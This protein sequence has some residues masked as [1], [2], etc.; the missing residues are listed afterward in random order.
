MEYLIEPTRLT[1]GAVSWS[2]LAFLALAGPLVAWRAHRSMRE[3]GRPPSSP[4]ARTKVYVGAL[5]WLW[6][7]VLLA[8]SAAR[9]SG[10]V[11]FPAWRPGPRDLAIGALS[12]ALGML[13]LLP[14]VPLVSDEG[15]ARVRAVAP[16]TGRERGLF[17][18]LCAAAGVGEEVIYRG[19]LFLLLAWLTGSW[20]AAALLAASVFG[21]VHLYQGP[22][23]A[24]VAGLYGLRD[25][26]VVGLT[27]TLWVAIVV[28]AAHDA[29]LGTVVGRRAA[30]TEGVGREADPVAD[31]RDELD[32]QGIRVDEA[33]LE[34]VRQDALRPPEPPPDQRSGR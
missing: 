26:V 19:V 16:R 24:F 5:V 33:F 1:P 23:A 10:M 28:H 34:Q 21:A 12:F 2:M 22:R 20:W 25:H 7:L 27:G 3:R 14:R 17:Y 18:L 29:L 32:R 4:S 13:T 15:R 8:W 9:E 30:R 31:L 11:L 6:V